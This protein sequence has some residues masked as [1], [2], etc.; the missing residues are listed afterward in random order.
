MEKLHFSVKKTQKYKEKQENFGLI[1]T[2]NSR[3]KKVNSVSHVLTP[4]FDR[5]RAPERA[6]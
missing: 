5:G 3:R 4:F 6:I 2:Q 1:F